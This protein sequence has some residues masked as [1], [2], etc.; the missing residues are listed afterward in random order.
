CGPRRLPDSLGAGVIGPVAPQLRILATPPRPG[1]RRPR[2]CGRM[3]TQ[4]G[5]KPLLRE[6]LRAQEG[7]DDTRRIGAR[8]PHARGEVL[9]SMGRV[10]GAQSGDL[11][12][13][14]ALFALLAEDARVTDISPLSGP[15]GVLAHDDR[16][17]PIPITL[18]LKRF[19]RL[20]HSWTQQWVYQ[21]LIADPST[22][23]GATG[24]AL[25]IENS[26][27]QHFE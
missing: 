12:G 21:Q 15:D 16:I 18:L 23:T 13:R 3:M 25:Q 11:G 27:L 2:P 14:D 8:S 26:L 24:R 6:V 22:A 5:D 20:W 10:L 9:V 19:E 17:A 1:R 7:R 4:A